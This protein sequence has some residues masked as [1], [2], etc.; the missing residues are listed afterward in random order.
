[1]IYRLVFEVKFKIKKLGFITIQN[2]RSSEQ[3]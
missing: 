3:E 1:M 2:T